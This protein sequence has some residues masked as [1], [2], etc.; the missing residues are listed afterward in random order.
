VLLLFALGLMAKPMLVTLPLVLLLLDVWPLDRVSLGTDLPGRSP[1]A[2]LRQQRTVW[3]H[4]VREKLPLL[5]LA[6]ASSIVTLVVQQQW[7]AVRPLDALP[8]SLR[9]ANALV[10]YVAYI[11]KMLWPTRLAAF[12]PY[13]ASV[14]GWWV[15]GSLAV[16][17][18]VSVVAM[19]AARRHPYLPM[20]WLWYLG[21]LVPVIGLIQVGSQ[22]LADRY[23]YVPLI[24]LFLMVAWGIPDLLARC[25][26]R[27]ITVPTAAGLVLLACAMTART[28][29]KYWE[30]SGALWTHALE[31]TTEN[32]RAHNNLGLV[33]AGQGRV[34][35]AI[36]HYNEA[37]RI[38]PRFVE[39]HNNLANVLAN[40]GR[41]TQGSRRP[42]RR[43]AADQAP[44]CRGAQQPGE[45]PGEP[46]ESRGSPHPLRR[47]SPHQARPCGRA[48]Q[49]GG[50]SGE[51]R[52]VQRGH[53]PL[54]RG[55]AHQAG[56]R[57]GTQQLRARF[58]ETRTGQRG[59]RPLRR[60]PADRPERSD[61]SACV[62]QIDET[63]QG[64]RAWHSVSM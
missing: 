39:A 56:V 27:S 19:R 36:A 10:S 14:P 20:G 58:D 55:P 18:G 41:E 31:I 22:S 35:E 1:F 57:G 45:R 2:V 32:D 15:V 43:G 21:T 61:G 3:F 44:P 40:Q 49:P 28:Q 64:V 63:R 13:P 34:S 6:L 33:L 5:A 47:G 4:L 23:T 11:G 30:N 37:V 59:D 26:Y 48:Q 50:R 62:G 60:G 16:V 12:Y 17:I 8:L 9:M 25:R 52:T 38:K 46:G 53:R 29:V 24:G 42:L 7:G 51:A 54:R